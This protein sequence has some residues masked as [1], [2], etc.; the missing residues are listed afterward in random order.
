MDVFASKCVQ[1]ALFN[2]LGTI[3]ATKLSGRKLR[4][5][6]LVHALTWGVLRGILNVCWYQQLAVYVPGRSPRDVLVKVSLAQ[7]VYTPVGSV[8]PRLVVMA[9]L[10]GRGVA[11]GV[12]DIR[13][14]L[15]S[16]L[17]VGW[18]LWPFVHAANF[19]LVPDDWQLL[20]IWTT[21]LVYITVI[22]LLSFNAPAAKT[23]GGAAKAK[24][25]PKPP[26]SPPR[27]NPPRKAKSKGKAE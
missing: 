22:E 10:E 24:R 26:A 21:S 16:Q 2:V 25:T 4:V 3:I 12:A 8:A 19:F 27:R 15:W 14:Q 6:P 23:A 13:Q 11:A 5:V 1:C 17:L 20:A 18:K 7:L 9:V